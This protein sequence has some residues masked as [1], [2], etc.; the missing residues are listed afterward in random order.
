M[1]TNKHVLSTCGSIRHDKILKLLFDWINPKL[2]AGTGIY[3]D[4][5]LPN[6]KPIP[7]LFINF[8][9]D[10]AVASTSGVGVLELTV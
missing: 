9:P 2:D 8:R 10:I 7:D 1:Q 4:L 3:Y 5:A 6:C